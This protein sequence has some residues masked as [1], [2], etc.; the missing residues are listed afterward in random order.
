MRFIRTLTFVFWQNALLCKYNFCFGIKKLFQ[1]FIVF[2]LYD[3]FRST[4]IPTDGQIVCFLTR[5]REEK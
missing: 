3:C 1:D 4:L 2:N 5:K